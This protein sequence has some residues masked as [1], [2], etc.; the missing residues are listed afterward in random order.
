MLSRLLPE[1]AGSIY[2]LMEGEGLAEATHLWGQ[3]AAETRAM[4]SAEE[5]QC[6]L[7]KRVHLGRG[8]LAGNHLHA[9]WCRT[10]RSSVPP[11]SR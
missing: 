6:M 5:C 10:A 8:D 9:R 2:P 1:S 3:H 4:A 11:A 7:D